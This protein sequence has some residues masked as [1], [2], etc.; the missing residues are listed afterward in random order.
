LGDSS[1]IALNDNDIVLML[2]SQMIGRPYRWAGNSP[3]E[4]MDCSGFICEIL[5]SKGVLKKHEDLSAQGLFNR[6]KLNISNDGPSFGKLSFYGKSFSQIS[7]VGF[8][9]NNKLMIEAGGGD[10]TTINV[11]KANEMNAYIRIRPIKYRTDFL[12]IVGTP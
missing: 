5:R 7:H 1:N 3:V 6:F 11:A 2:I 12:C 10:S 8:C 9:L 4:G